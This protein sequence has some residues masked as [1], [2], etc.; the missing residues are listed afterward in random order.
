MK[1]SRSC[2]AFAFL[3]L[4]LVM[5]AAVAASLPAQQD[6]D[7]NVMMWQKDTHR[8]GQNQNEGFLVSPLTGVGQLCN[9][10]VDGQVYAQPRAVSDVTF[11][12]TTYTSV[13]SVVTQNE[14]VYA[15]N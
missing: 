10:P 5:V 13:V 2:N 3:I 8:T 6:R 1:R 4:V 12:G 7:V 14:S 11:N 9:I 15:A